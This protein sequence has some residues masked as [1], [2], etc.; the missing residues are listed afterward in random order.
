MNIYTSVEEYLSL[1]NSL[2]PA[3][4]ISMYQDYEGI[5]RVRVDLPGVKT[6]VVDGHT[7]LTEALADICTQLLNAGVI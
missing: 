2:S 7:H 1:L 3:T 5:I 6:V 4:S